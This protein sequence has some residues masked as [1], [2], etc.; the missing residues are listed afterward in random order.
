MSKAR[1]EKYTVS[2]RSASLLIREGRHSPRNIVSRIENP[3]GMH[4]TLK[5]FVDYAPLVDMYFTVKGD[6]HYFKFLGDIA[7]Q[8][9]TFQ[10]EGTDPSLPRIVAACSCPALAAIHV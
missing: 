6:A 10:G 4:Q 7:T 9:E 1:R 5:R 8:R 3:M 2:A